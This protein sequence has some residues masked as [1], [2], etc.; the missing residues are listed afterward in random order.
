MITEKPNT[1]LLTSPNLDVKLYLDVV[2]TEKSL[3]MSIKYSSH[4]PYCSMSGFPVLKMSSTLRNEVNQI[5]QT[6]K[7]EDYLYLINRS[8]VRFGILLTNCSFINIIKQANIDINQSDMNLIIATILAHP[9]MRLADTSSPLCIPGLA[10]DGYIYLTIKFFTPNVGVIFAGLSP[11]N[12]YESITKAKDIEKMLEQK[13]LI[14]EITNAIKDNY[15]RGVPLVT[16][17]ICNK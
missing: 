5:M 10:D 9:S 16:N 3:S 1:Q 2:E 8:V 14:E 13:G 15:M 11:E 17:G 4:T 7:P 12:F 6:N